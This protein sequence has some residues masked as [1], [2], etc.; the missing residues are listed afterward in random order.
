[1]KGEKR[2]WGV[3]MEMLKKGLKEPFIKPS[4][5]HGPMRRRNPETARNEP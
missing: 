3:E 1:M 4:Q 2:F 5:N